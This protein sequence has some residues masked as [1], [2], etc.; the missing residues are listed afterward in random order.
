[1]HKLLIK[2]ICGSVGGKTSRKKGISTIKCDRCGL[3]RQNIEMTKED[4]SKFYDKEYPKKFH[5]FEH[6]KKVAKKRLD[7]YQLSKGIKL[8]DVGCGNG[9]FVQEAV[10]AGVEAYGTD[11]L[12]EDQ[13]KAGDFY[14][15][16]LLDVNF[17]TDHFDVITVHDVFEHFVDPVE[18][19]NEI[20]RILKQ[21]GTLILDLP[22]FHSK[23]GSHHWKRI[24]H[25]WFPTMDQML[26]MLADAGFQ[27]NK[28]DKPI[29]GKLVFYSQKPIQKRIS[30]LV[31]PGVGDIYWAMTKMQSFLKQNGLGIPDVCISSPNKYEKDHSLPF[32]EKIPFINAAGYA[33]H[34]CKPT[35]K[36]WLIFQEAYRENGRAVIKDV[37]GCDY[38]MSYNGLLVNGVGLDSPQLRYDTNWFFPMFKS[39]EERKAEKD[40][41]REHGSYIV[42]YFIPHGMYANW[43]SQFDL[44]SISGTLNKIT[45]QTGKKILLVGGKWDQNTIERD[46]IGKNKDIINMVG[47]TTLPQA[48]GIVN[49]ASGTIGY[50]SGITIMSAI[51]KRP[52]LL[53]WNDYFH[54]SFF[55]NAVPPQARGNWYNIVNTRSTS[56]DEITNRFKVLM[57]N[58]KP[59]PKTLFANPVKKKKEMVFTTVKPKQETFDEQ[60]VVIHK[61]PSLVKSIKPL[62]LTVL[63]SG[64]DFGPDYVN[65]MK[66]MI[67]NHIDTD[68]DFL[69]LTDDKRMNGN[70]IIPLRHRWPGWWSKLEVFRKDIVGD[71]KAIYFDL[72]M[73]IIDNI[74]PLT[75]MKNPFTM[76][77]GFK[78]K[79]KRNSSIMVWEGNGFSE[80]YETASQSFSEEFLNQRSNESDQ[81]FIQDRLLSQYAITPGVVQDAVQVS[82]FKKDYLKQGAL[83]EDT[84]IVSFHGKP[85]PHEISKNEMPKW[86]KEN[87]IC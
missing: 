51:Y 5:S 57:D 20:F 35:D 60:K 11:I 25:L 39:L 42:A 41:I 43:I 84:R 13:C 27:I 1:M 63:K 31:P 78:D 28:V 77:R 52:T 36:E 21:K 37:C 72:D 56:A 80:L 29:S 17:P 49:G 38:L 66:N 73:V 9:A 74:F 15:Q 85:R 64:G 12:A 44:A 45:N 46:V 69:C 14:N 23:A 4:L 22:D 19:L 32:V 7:V 26:G 50:P 68:Y 2:C 61:K 75:C 10:K 81:E 18:Q 70:D 33:K 30:I 58:W 87:W 76:M 59:K 3:I 55:W 53:F 79:D 67:K 8:L 86:M 54:H 82:S 83:L 16:P 34:S 6:D 40:A 48:F 65:K 62:I 24:E 71:R 47:K